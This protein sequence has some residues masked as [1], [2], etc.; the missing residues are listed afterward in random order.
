MTESEIEPPQPSPDL[1]RPSSIPSVPDLFLAFATMSLH[2]FGGVLPWARRMIVE[3]RKWMTAEEFNDAFALCQFLPG[4]NIVNF[5]VVYG[6]RLHGVAGAAAAF[7]GL[8]APPVAI[9]IALGALYARFGDVAALRGIL[10][11][12]AA[13]AA[14]LVVAMAAKMA[15]PL[16]RGGLTIAPFIAAGVYVA[17]GIMRWPLLHVLLVAAPISVGIAWWGRR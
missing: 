13:A 16:L 2:G 11:G 12:V 1:H 4:P 7:L 14:G 9:V 8:I 3:E 15:A 10:A 17:A 6:A 5:S